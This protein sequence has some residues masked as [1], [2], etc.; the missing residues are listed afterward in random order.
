[1]WSLGHLQCSF[2][3]KARGPKHTVAEDSVLQMLAGSW[4]ALPD[5]H[6]P[7]PC[8]PYRQHASCGALAHGFDVPAAVAVAVAIPAHSSTTSSTGEAA[9][10]GGGAVPLL[11]SEDY[12]NLD[13]RI[14]PHSADQRVSRPGA[15]TQKKT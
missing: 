8:W 5:T 1:M 2:F 11:H 15:R 13:D 4:P 7:L 9:A 10:A 3:F 12:Q 6:A 14:G